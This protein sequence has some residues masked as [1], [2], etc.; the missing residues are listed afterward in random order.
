MRADK[1]KLSLYLEIK[2]QKFPTSCLRLFERLRKE[3]GTPRPSDKFVSS[4]GKVER[5]VGAGRRESFANGLTR[6]YTGILLQIIL[7]RRVVVYSL[8]TS[9]TPAKII[10]ILL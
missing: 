9:D 7:F 2:L 6:N 3:V 8:R 5:A 1:E 4:K 10:L